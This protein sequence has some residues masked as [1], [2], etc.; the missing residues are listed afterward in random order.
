LSARRIGSHIESVG[1]SSPATVINS[2]RQWAQ[3]S[4]ERRI[5]FREQQFFHVRQ[6][7]VAETSLRLGP[8]HDPERL[9]VKRKEENIVGG[10]NLA[11][12]SFERD[13]SG[14]G[15]LTKVSTRV[16]T[17]DKSQK[18]ETALILPPVGSYDVNKT[19]GSFYSDCDRD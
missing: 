7:R 1:R 17:V 8:R 9:L 18:R 13:A 2:G 5:L 12:P 6:I 11:F 14:R 10:S 19:L 3:R 4:R 16:D 15:S